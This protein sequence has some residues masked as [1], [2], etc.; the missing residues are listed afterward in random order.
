MSLS[1]RLLVGSLACALL[2]GTTGCSTFDS[3][4]AKY[5]E[6]FGALPTAVIERLKT[7]E[8]QLGDTATMVYV[9]FGRPDETTEQITAAGRRRTW[10]YTDY[11]HEY[12]GTRFVGYRRY[13]VQDPATKT[14][15][16]VVDPEYQPVYAPRAEDRLRVTFENDLVVVVEQVRPGG[17]APVN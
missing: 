2:L 5:P 13:V 6:V 8:I 17:E 3:R 15:R 7:G 12:Q 9:A 1:F 11:W 16:V 4:A 14:P 10:T